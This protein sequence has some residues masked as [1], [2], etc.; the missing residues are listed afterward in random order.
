MDILRKSEKE[1]EGVQER[2]T[3]FFEAWSSLAVLELVTILPHLFSECWDYK[4]APPHLAE[5][6]VAYYAV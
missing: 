4:Q 1:R 6:L 5:M 3:L 2:K